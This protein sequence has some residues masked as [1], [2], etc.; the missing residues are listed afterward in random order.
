M[1]LADVGNRHIHIYED[2]RI[3]H[4]EIDE[5]ISYFARQ[6]IK[7]ISVNPKVEDE[8]K[9]RTFWLNISNQIHLSG[10]YEGMGVDRKALCLSS[11]D[12]I[13]ID[14]GSAI[15]IDKVESGR[16]IGG[17]IFPG[18]FAYKRAYNSI[19][20]RLDFDIDELD[21]VNIDRFPKGTKNQIAYAILR[22]II[23]TVNS[24]RGRLPLYITGGDMMIFSPFFQDANFSQGFVFEGMKKALR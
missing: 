21:E 15:T 23:D 2:G 12:G 22:P 20:E 11:G 18:F 3:F 16:Y 8:I 17:A 9:R 13:Y 4:L 10:E 24:I 14:A 5:A 1:I 7:Y 6:K 19:S